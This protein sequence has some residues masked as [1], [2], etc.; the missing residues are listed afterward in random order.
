[1]SGFGKWLETTLKE[2]S[3]SRLFV[4][5]IEGVGRQQE[6]CRVKKRR[7]PLVGLLVPDLLTHALFRTD[8]GR[9]NSVN[10]TLLHGTKIKSLNTLIPSA[11][12][13]K[14]IACNS[15]K[16]MLG[17]SQKQFDVLAEVFS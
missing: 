10:F 11:T 9:L 12:T 4:A 3:P 7:T 8:Q 17:A 1:M 15:E 14:R 13:E 5:R 2:L 6:L 16:M